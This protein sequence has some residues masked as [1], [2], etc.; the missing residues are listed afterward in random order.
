MKRAFSAA[1]CLLSLALLLA[2]CAPRVTGPGDDA[3]QDAWDGFREDVQDALEDR[4]DDEQGKAHYY[5]ILDSQGEELRTVT[6]EA[7][8]ASL[9]ELLGNAGEEL[10]EAPPAEEPV[11]CVYVYQQEKTLL[12]GQDPEAERE[13]EEV[14]R[15]TVYQEKD[16]VTMEILAGKDVAGISLGDLLTFTVSM[17]EEAMEQLRN[18]AGLDG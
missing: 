15:F 9:D 12:A 16:L 6:D 18:P 4:N 2:A 5:Q 10:E 7:Q 14:I 3:F 8:V 11:A 17:P 13:Y 1:L